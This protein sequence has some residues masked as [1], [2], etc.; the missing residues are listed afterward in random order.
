MADSLISVENVSKI[1]HVYNHPMDRLKQLLFKSKKRFYKEVI[2]L[3]DIS[4]NVPKGQILG[5]IGKNG[6]G[7]STLLAILAG[8]IQPTSGQIKIKGNATSLLELAAGLNLEF[9][10]A[11][12]IYHYGL[13]MG[14]TKKHLNQ[15]FQKIVEFAEIGQF[16]HRPLKTY[17]TGMIMRLAF[18]VITASNSDIMLID[19][20]ASVGDIGFQLKCLRWLENFSHK[21]GTVCMVS[22]DLNLIANKCDKVILLEDGC[23]KKAG[24]SFEV[25]QH[26]R[27][28]V[29]DNQKKDK[30]VNLNLSTQTAEASSG[31]IPSNMPRKGNGRGLVTRVL[32]NGL[33][34]DAQIILHKLQPIEVY[35]EAVF[36]ESFDD[37]SFGFI[38]V[39]PKGA[40]IFSVSTR[41][42]TAFHPQIKPGQ[43]VCCRLKINQNLQPGDYYLQVGI[44]NVQSRD[45]AELLDVIETHAKI[46]VTGI[47]RDIGFVDFPYSLNIFTKEMAKKA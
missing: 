25:V 8:T 23:I 38:I 44:A 40:D 7:K 14:Q 17:S 20:V 12:N 11:E 33:P 9:T 2:A 35:M 37:Y 5:I 18:A 27:Y 4:F 13:L 31:F 42:T 34:L 19:E 47:S 24:S 28:S 16:L 29:F 26:F 21:G 1:Y 39:S 22:H 15:N 10:G 32:I 41:L 3:K 45:I 30:N 43:P 6:A 36:S 46:T